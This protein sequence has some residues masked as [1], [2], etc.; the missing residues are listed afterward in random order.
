[1]RVENNLERFLLTKGRFAYWRSLFSSLGANRFSEVLD[2]LERKGNRIGVPVELESTGEGQI[3]VVYRR[4]RD[5]RATDQLGEAKAFR[6]GSTKLKFAG[7]DKANW[8]AF[9]YE[10]APRPGCACAFAG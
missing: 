4:G 7:L 1:M 5:Y 10:R 9:R 8:C 2:W 6:V 3:M